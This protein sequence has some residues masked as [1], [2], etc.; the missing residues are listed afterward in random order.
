MLDQI[1]NFIIPT[2][3]AD[4][5]SALGPN[6]QGGGI[7]F[8]VMLVGFFLLMYFFII[9]PQ[10]K[11]AKEQQTMVDALAKGDE[12]VTAGGL[13]GRLTKLS[14]PYMTV[15][16]ANNVEIVMQKSSVITVLPKGTLKTIE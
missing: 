9:R 11:R 12:V 16:V 10:N 5:L 2:A 6:P 3:H 14:G 8:V 1:L 7:S 13:L 15:T 4:A